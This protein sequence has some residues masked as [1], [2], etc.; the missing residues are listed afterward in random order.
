MTDSV[1]LEDKR[2]ST[3]RRG[4]GEGSI[5]LRHDG[6]W[7]AVLNIGYDTS[8]RRRRK[9]VYGKTKAEVANK[10]TELQGKRLDGT[11]T[12][13]RRM[14]VQEFLAHWL[15]TFVKGQVRRTTYS[16]YAGAVRRH[17][18][19]AIGGMQL[20]KLGPNHVQAI[21]ARMEAN[22]KS[23]HVRRHVHIVL[24]KACK[25]AVRW[26]MLARNPVDAVDSPRVPK[27]EAKS[28]TLEQS[29]AILAAAK[30][31]KFEAL[32]VLALTTGMRIGEL[33]G[34]QWESVNLAEGW[35]I[36]RHSLEDVSGKLSLGEPKSAKSRRKV[37]LSPLAVTALW[38]HRK[39]MLAK[40]W[41]DGYVFRNRRGGPV[42][43]N[44]FRTFS[45][46][47]LLERAGVPYIKFHTTR[48]T[49]ASLA[50]ADGESVKLVSEMLGHAN[51]SI[52]LNVYAHVLPTQH[53][54]RANRMGEMLGTAA[55]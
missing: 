14:T 7:C 30:G 3:R 21:Y 32:Y 36:V 45:Y 41:T 13:C 22:G 24:H 6:T 10:L 33:F 55:G 27:T 42:Y 38:E 16:I 40:G 49:A 11:L 19:P 48:H 47:P 51:A 17:I 26:G 34:L 4:N 5:C 23:G 53:R 52:T 54:A 44:H 43:R 15:E 31:D 9:F 1:T 50:L 29:R 37:E 39:R 12:D 2:R 18:N 25:Q 20:S 28:F 46:K 35:L 8:G